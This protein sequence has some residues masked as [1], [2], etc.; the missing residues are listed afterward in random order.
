MGNIL[1]I[2]DNDTMR[3]GME[4]II[5]K[6]GHQV[7]QAR[8][9]YEGLKT[10]EETPIDL[11]LTD[12]K[13][14]G[15]SGLEVLE[16]VRA[17]DPD[18]LVTIMTAFGTIE[19]AVEAMKKGAI[20][21][22]TK[23]FSQ[24]LLRAKVNLAMGYQ[25]LSDANR[26]L[27]RENELLRA[28]SA[29]E[30]DVSEMVGQAPRMQE[31]FARARKIARSDSSVLVTGESGTGKEL[32]ARAIHFQS[33]RAGQPFIKVNC[34]ALAE[35]V[36]ESELFGHEKGSFTGAV[37]RKLGRFELADKG[38]IFLDEIGDISPVIQLKLLRVLQEREF[39][40]VG[41]TQTIRVD[42]RFICATNRNLL[43]EIQAGRFREDLYY[44]VNTVP[45]QLPPLRERS[46]DI[47]GLV[48]HF[49]RKLR[50]RTKKEVRGVAPDALEA[51]RRHGWPGNIRELE[52]VIEQ[53]MV[54]C[55]GDVLDASDLPLF[56]NASP[57]KSDLS[58]VLGQKPLPDI[59]DDIERDLIKE[60]YQRAGQVKTETARLLGI[61]TSALYYKLE[62]YGLI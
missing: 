37:K 51:L 5:A 42:V 59:L 49:L 35:G 20:D 14:E 1:V 61:K 4:K 52:N 31:T 7:F 8:N 25:S 48:D 50:V 33:D 60:A 26:R 43:D 9:G 34:S 58:S 28:E 11:V 16:K 39:E 2:E 27:S 46:E 30:Y 13:M 57:K 29:L 10:F 44:R 56:G 18:A 41:G 47:P 38:S 32:V 45:L 21:F 55:D 36:L 3:E 6:M 54:L 15:M 62:K 24:D 19:T 17:R 12:M 53:A 22:L 23:P 40:R